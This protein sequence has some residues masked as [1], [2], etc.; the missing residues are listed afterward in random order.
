MLRSV[1]ACS[2]SGSLRVPRARLLSNQR[3]QAR[4]VD[5]GF[6]HAA[7]AETVW[8][9]FSS[10]SSEAAFSTTSAPAARSKAFSASLPDLYSKLTMLP[11]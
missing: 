6:E 9:R 5:G 11:S 1:A 2:P 10:T 8:T 3:E 7:H 4:A